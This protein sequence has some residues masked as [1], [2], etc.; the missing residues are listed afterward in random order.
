LGEWINGP[1]FVCVGEKAIIPEHVIWLQ[2]KKLRI[3][4]NWWSRTI[5][6]TGNEGFNLEV[7]R[8][9]NRV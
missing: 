6:V 2:G 4:N 9:K 8:I 1:G 5:R 3:C 7:I